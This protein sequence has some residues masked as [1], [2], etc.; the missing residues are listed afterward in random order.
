MSQKHLGLAYETTGSS[1]VVGPAQAV[2]EKANVIRQKEQRDLEQ[3]A[4]QFAIAVKE[5]DAWEQAALVNEREVADRD[6]QG[7][8]EALR[9]PE[10][11]WLVSGTWAIVSLS[12]SPS[13]PWRAR[14]G[15][16]FPCSILESS[17]LRQLNL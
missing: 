13:L 2:E 8:L 6:A 16:P 9:N 15:P 17:G 12:S 10:E 5:R 11:E 1:I 3:R 7:E 4:A 14:R